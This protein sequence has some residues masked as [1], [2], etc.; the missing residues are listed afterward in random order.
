MTDHAHMFILFCDVF[1][2]RL[3]V[4]NLVEK[5][6]DVAVDSAMRIF[7]AVY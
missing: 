3:F 6:N 5:L 4:R 2:Q 1:F 7:C